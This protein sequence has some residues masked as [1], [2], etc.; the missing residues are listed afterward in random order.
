M[1]AR[2]RAE[3][4]VMFRLVL[5]VTVLW[6]AYLIAALIAW[7]WWLEFNRDAMKDPDR[8]KALTNTPAVAEAFLGP[9][10]RLFRRIGDSS[11]NPGP[12]GRAALRGA[13]GRKRRGGGTQNTRRTRA[14]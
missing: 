1:S 12:A 9:L 3:R 8:A 6:V 11:A 4:L 2:E 7:R 14:S 13:P 10:A 5:I